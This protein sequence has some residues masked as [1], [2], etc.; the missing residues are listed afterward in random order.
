M[1][2]KT[3]R[4]QFGHIYILYIYS[5]SPTLTKLESNPHRRDLMFPVGDANPSS[6][7]N[8]QAC[9]MLSED[10]VLDMDCLATLI[11]VGHSRIPVYG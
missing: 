4:P 6:G 3:A 8:R 9:F 1:E 11:S 7:G 2:D 10:D 5:L